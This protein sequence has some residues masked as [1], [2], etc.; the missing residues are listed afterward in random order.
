MMLAEACRISGDTAKMEIAADRVIAIEPRAVRAY[1]WKGDARMAAGDP[2]GAARWYREGVTQSSVITPLPDA[3]VGEVARIEEALAA[4]EAQFDRQLHEGMAARG[5]ATDAMSERFAESLALLRGEKT[6]QL[7]RPKAHYLPGLA[8]R[9]FFDRAEFAWAAA[10]EGATG[11]ITAELQAAMADDAALF[12]PY[13]KSDTAAPARDFHGMVDNPDWEALH[14][15]ENGV[16]SPV[17]QARFPQTLAAMEYAPLCKIG[18]RAPTVMFSRLRSGKR[19]PPH[20]GMINSRLIC[21][22]PLIVPGAGGLRC[23]NHS[24]SWHVGELMIFDDSMEHEAWNDADADR[25]VLIFDIWRP[26]V[27]AAERAALVALFDVIDAA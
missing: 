8:Q 18:V 3:L 21:H 4:L 13:L 27:S 7:Q 15:I 22:L 24:R 11:A 17:N 6:I 19:I 25:I 1:G 23:G 16:A 12:A 2:R 26:D 9:P 20:H 10:V 5:I 14:L